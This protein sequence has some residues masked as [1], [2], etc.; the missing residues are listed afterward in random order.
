MK[1]RI[2]IFGSLLTGAVAR[3][4]GP[5]PEGPGGLSA[6]FYGGLSATDVFRLAPP[7]GPAADTAGSAP[8]TG[9]WVSRQLVRA[10]IKTLEAKDAYTKG[11]SERVSAYCLRMAET[12]GLDAA[13]RHTLKWAAL[14]HDLGKLKTPRRVL[15]KPGRLSEEEFAGIRRHPDH[16]VRILRPIGPLQDALP[17][18]RHHHERHDGRGYPDGLTAGSI[19]LLARVIAVADTYD[20]I[21]SRRAY[22]RSRPHLEAVRLI[23]AAAGS[24]FDPAVVEAFQATVGGDGP[25]RRTRET[26]PGGGERETRQ[27]TGDPLR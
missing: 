13:Q 14:L 26:P 27:G 18:I 8:E 7:D 19:P 4:V 15:N 20:A 24:Q 11:H 6:S 3:I 5:P 10:L 9:G 21:T 2:G 16:G 1:A 17:A 25:A 23:A 12:L 22:R